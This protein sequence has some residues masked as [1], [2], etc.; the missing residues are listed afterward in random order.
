MPGG[1]PT[2]FRLSKLSSNGRDRGA[3]FCAG[4]RLGNFSRRHST[5]KIFDLFA[6]AGHCFYRGLQ[7][8]HKRQQKLRFSSKHMSGNGDLRLSELIPKIVRV[9]LAQVMVAFGKAITAPSRQIGERL[10]GWIRLKKIQRYLGFQI[11]KDLERTRV[12][13]FKRYPN[14][15]KKSGFLETQEVVIPSKHLKLLGF[16]GDGLKSAQMSMISAQ[17]LRQNISIK[18]IALRLT[19]AKPIPRSIQRLGIHRIDHYSVIQKKIHN[20]SVG[21]LNGRPK[22]NPLAAAL[23]KP[24]PELSQLICGLLDLPLSYF[25]APLISYIQLMAFVRPIHSEIIS[26]QFLTLLFC[27]LPIPITVNGKFI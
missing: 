16:G 19:N 4:Q 18:G 7:L 2:V 15:I 11:N 27:L 3:G 6:I 22:L 12:I 8:N 1:L 17:K 14:L 24:A 23:V 9:C 25:S 21:L 13:L 5:E 10:R 26:L 20:A